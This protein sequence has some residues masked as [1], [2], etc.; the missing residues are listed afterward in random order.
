MRMPEFHPFIELVPCDLETLAKQFDSM[1]QEKTRR[2]DT[3]D[4][5]KAITV[6]R[7][8]GIREDGMCMAAAFTYY[9]EDP[10]TEPDFFPT[11]KV[12]D[13]SFIIGMGLAVPFTPAAGA[14]LQFGTVTGHVG[15]K[16]V[17]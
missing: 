3:E 5:K 11:D 17:F 2:K 15:I 4:K 10:D 6:I 13:P 12:R 14:C 1:V 7:N 8:D 16:E 9:A